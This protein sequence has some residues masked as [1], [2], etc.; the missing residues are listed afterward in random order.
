MSGHQMSRLT[1]G[2]GVGKYVYT[3]AE[4]NSADKQHRE[5]GDWPPWMEEQGGIMKVLLKKFA[6]MINDFVPQEFAQ[7]N[8]PVS[9]GRHDELGPDEV[10]SVLRRLVPQQTQKGYGEFAVFRR[11]ELFIEGKEGIQAVCSSAKETYYGCNRM[12][13]ILS[14]IIVWNRLTIVSKAFQIVWNAFE[15]VLN[16]L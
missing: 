12:V 14:Y 2:G 8:L 11:A 10:Q 7:L 5:A 4:L 16:W 15:T 13:R 1:G 6:H 9:T 3:V